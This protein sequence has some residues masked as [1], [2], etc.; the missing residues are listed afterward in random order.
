M[1]EEIQLTW[2]EI[3]NIK[4]LESALNSSG[5]YIWLMQFD[6]K[7]IPYYVGESSN[8][9]KRLGNHLSCLLGGLYDIYPV[10]DMRNF[11][12]Y[13]R[14][15]KGLIYS[16]ASD[17]KL[18]DFV[19]RFDEIK[20]HLIG[21]I[22]NFFFTFATYIHKREDINESSALHDIEKSIINKIGFD[23]LSNANGGEPYYFKVNN[24]LPHQ[25]EKHFKN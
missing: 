6:G 2:S 20:P 24:T 1:Q 10:S 13:K 21:M 15:K 23:N 5:L 14:D 22:Q 9:R 16:P 4:Q 17:L 18:L 12:K 8:I 7:L 11:V 3:Y 19:D 25:I